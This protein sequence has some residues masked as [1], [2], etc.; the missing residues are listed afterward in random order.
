MNFFKKS[1]GLSQSASV[2]T[3]LPASSLFAPTDP[4]TSN[5]TTSGFSKKQTIFHLSQRLTKERLF[6]AHLSLTDVFC[7][8]NNL[9]FQCKHS[10]VWLNCSKNKCAKEF[11]IVMLLLLSLS[12]SCQYSS[13]E[14]LAFCSTEVFFFL[15]EYPSLKFTF[16]VSSLSSSFPFNAP[17]FSFVRCPAQLSSLL[18]LPLTLPW[19]SS[20]FLYKRE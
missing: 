5:L 20:S 14:I 2:N 16:L 12:L 4:P 7:S 17:L 10:R 9:N 15:R 19:L 6:G 13:G 8:P 11:E 18:L 3:Q 1:T